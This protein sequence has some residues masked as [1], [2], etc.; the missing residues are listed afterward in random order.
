M[1]KFHDSAG[2]PWEGRAFGANP[3]SD[4][5]GSTP[6]DVA[7]A[8]AKE[9]FSLTNLHRSLLPN[10]LLVPLIAQL[11]DLEVGAHGKVVDKS[12]ELT[13]VA[14]ATPDGQSAI[15]AFTS[16]AQ[17]QLWKSDARPVPIE[18]TRVALAAIA[19]GHNR[20]V[21]NPGTDS[22]GLRRPFLAALAQQK[23]WL[24][25]G[26]NPEVDELVESAVSSFPEITSFL[27]LDADPA[28]TLRQAELTIQLGVR[29]GLSSDELS[30][31][32]LQFSQQLQSIRFLE[33]VDSVSLKVS[34]S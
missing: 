4:D 19:E 29:A 23:T 12:A 22:I 8:L 20:V 2:V 24:S 32:L 17:M 9:S 6:A 33:L 13:I 14:V 18:A 31:L 21:L 16:V 26:E 15:P 10:R 30:E 11:G 5:D 27:L 1:D 34:A 3:F 28:G 25:P 7:H